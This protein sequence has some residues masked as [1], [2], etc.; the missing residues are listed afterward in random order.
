M[1][2][3]TMTERA[4]DRSA[5]RQIA[6][7]QLRCAIAEEYV[8]KLPETLTIDE[9]ARFAGMT[10]G[11][12][13][14]ATTTGDLVVSIREGHRGIAPAD[15]VAFLLRERML[16][17][18]FDKPAWPASDRSLSISEAAYERVW[19]EAVRSSTTPMD[20]LDRLILAS[21]A[22]SAAAPAPGRVE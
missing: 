11:Q 6:W 10:I 3:I 19:E 22:A 14:H 16:Q 5:V 9:F 17:L 21:T 18:H 8:S 2:D 13:R 1:A 12:V 7:L 20:A 15:N 4:S